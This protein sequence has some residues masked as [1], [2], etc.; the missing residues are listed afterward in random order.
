M[1]PVGE[2]GEKDPPPAFI[3]IGSSENDVLRVQGTPSKVEGERWYYGFAQLRFKEGRVKEY[4]NYFGNL[5]VRL[6]PSKSSDTDPHKNFFTI[7]S[8]PDEVLAAQGTPTSIHG[9]TWSFSFSSVTFR[10][11]KVNYVSNTDGGLH[12]VPTEEQS[13]KS[14]S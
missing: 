9:N 2:Y 5:K 10:D 1:Q 11:G 8:T 7:G 13:D 12:F 14:G 3:T 6:L 4:D